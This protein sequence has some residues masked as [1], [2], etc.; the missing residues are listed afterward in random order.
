[1][2][3][4]LF[5][6]LISTF[7]DHAVNFSRSGAAGA[8]NRRLA[9]TGNFIGRLKGPNRGFRVDSRGLAAK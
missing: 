4:D 1:M 8:A 7:S 5:G 6:K 9:T 3:H 2:R